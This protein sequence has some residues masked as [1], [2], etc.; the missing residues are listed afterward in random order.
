[1]SIEYTDDMHPR[2]TYWEMW[3]L[4]MFDVKPTTRERAARGARCREA[5]PEHH[6]KLIA[7]D[8]TYGRQT[9]A[10]SLHRQPPAVEKPG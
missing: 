5:H 8:A 6:I 9:S 10:L 7:Y 4:P 2:N 3:G 1:M